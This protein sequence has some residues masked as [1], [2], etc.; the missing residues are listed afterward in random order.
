MQDRNLRRVLASLHDGQ[1]TTTAISE[2]LDDIREKRTPKAHPPVNRLLRV[3]LMQLET[4]IRK[5]F[6]QRIIALMKK[7]A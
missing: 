7:I 2:I 6:A 1:R 3:D 5:H 4:M